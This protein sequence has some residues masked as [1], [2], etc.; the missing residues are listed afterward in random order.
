MLLINTYKEH[1][2]DFINPKISTK[3]C[4]NILSK[5]ME[6]A[7]YQICPTKCATK[8]QSLKRTY[9]SVHNKSDHNKKSG[10]SRKQWEY[11]EVYYL[12]EF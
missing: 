6:H 8:F 9:K 2:A 4:W 10:N 3:R 1:M 12:L 11:Y 7:G 5:E